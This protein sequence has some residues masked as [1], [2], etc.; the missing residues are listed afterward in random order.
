MQVTRQKL[1][2]LWDNLTK[3]D[4]DFDQVT[5]VRTLVAL[6]ALCSMFLPW[7]R[8]DGYSSSVNG[9]ELLA[10]AF[11]SPERGAMFRIAPLGAAALLFVPL[12]VTAT[13]VYN[14]VKNIQGKLTIGPNVALIMLPVL[15]LFLGQALTASD[16]PRLAGITIPNPGGILMILCNMGL[17]AHSLCTESQ[18]MRR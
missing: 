15:M 16:Q 13:A 1:S 12:A 6:L 8:L 9:A 17:L 4:P 18:S 14:F 2:N 3:G 10:F 7:V 5:Q 11:T